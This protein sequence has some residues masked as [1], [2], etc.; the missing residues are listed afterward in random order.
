MVGANRVLYNKLLKNVKE[1]KGDRKIT[2]STVIQST[3]VRLNHIPVNGQ[4]EN[5]IWGKEENLQEISRFPKSR[6]G[7]GHFEKGA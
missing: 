7:I 2:P 5:R 3:Q 6:K 4:R 1:C